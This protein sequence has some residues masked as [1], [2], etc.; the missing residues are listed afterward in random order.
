MIDFAETVNAELKAF[1]S[2]A[3]A[4]H[5]AATPLARKVL[6]SLMAGA[7]TQG[8]VTLAALAAYGNPKTPKGKPCTTLSGLRYAEAG[9]AMKKTLEKVFYLDDVRAIGSSKDSSEA[10]KTLGAAVNAVLTDFVLEREGAPKSLSAVL[11]QVEELC[12]A[13]A[14][15]EAEAKAKAE[16]EA[17][18]EAGEAGEAEAGEAKAEAAPAASELS[19]LANRLTIAL[20]SAS[21]EERIAAI[22]AIGKLYEAIEAVYEIGT[23]PVAQAA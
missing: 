19:E 23:P 20:N 15:A 5:N 3:I 22:D 6:A 10:D 8:K 21:D 9:E 4:S 13:A 18:A 2:K 7:L 11:T 12:I 14:K 17:K 16:A 1:R